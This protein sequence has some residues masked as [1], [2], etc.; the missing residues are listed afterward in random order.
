ME[1]AGDSPG[2][3]ALPTAFSDRPGVAVYRRALGHRCGSRGSW[4]VVSRPT[5]PTPA[6][7]L[8]PL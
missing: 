1:G 3:T 4:R 5:S 2:A 6:A 7:L 8:P